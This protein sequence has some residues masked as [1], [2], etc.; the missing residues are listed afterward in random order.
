MI[1]RVKDF[2]TEIELRKYSKIKKAK[3]ES[4]KEMFTDFIEE[5]EE[6][7]IINQNSDNNDLEIHE[8]ED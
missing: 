2:E 6:I 1:N 5:E 8:K 4:E 3:K 7:I